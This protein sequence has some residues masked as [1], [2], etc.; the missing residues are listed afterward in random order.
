MDLLKS[1]EKLKDKIAV[2]VHNKYETL[3][4]ISE[5][6]EL[7]SEMKNSLNEA[8]EKNIPKKDK[9]EHKK[10]INKEI[11]DLMEERG[12][13]KNV[14]AKYKDLNK[15]IKIK[16]NAAKEEWINQQCQ[17]IEQKLNI[18]SK[19]MHAKI[20]DVSG[21]KIKCS[22]PGCIKSKD[23]T[24]LLEKREILNRWSEY[25][26]DL[27]KDD[28][29]KTSKIKKKIEGPIILK[30]EVEP[31]IK[32]MKNG[33]ATGPDNIPVQ[34]I[35][36]LDN[37]GKVLT[38]KLLNAIYD[39]GTIPEDLC[40]SVFIVMPKTPGTT[41]CELHRTISLMSHFTKI[42]LYVLM[43]RMRKNIRPEISP[44][45]F[46]FMPDKGTRNAIFTLSMLMERCI[47]MQ[48]DLH[49]CFI[50]YSKAFDM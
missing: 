47:E 39:S 8:I 17:E 19:F 2:A 21:K 42:L 7:W 23:G 45:Q 12:K 36:A 35:K 32:K 26:E 3:K 49:L 44:K 30:E 4:N 48:K 5:V 24:M 18:D 22:S 9:K 43:H 33:K 38:T 28:E 37:L 13:S 46:G 14:E 27:F 34:I 10:W 11:L 41:E 15:N 1:D 40:K 31:A 6:E 16:C 29:C 20:K 50:D 25:V